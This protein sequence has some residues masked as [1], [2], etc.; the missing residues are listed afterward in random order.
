MR[1]YHIFT[2]RGLG[3]CTRQTGELSSRNTTSKVTGPCDH[4][5]TWSHVTNKKWY[6]STSPKAMTVKLGK[7][8]IYNKGPPFIKFFDALT[9]WW[10]DHVTDKN[11]IFLLPWELWLRNSTEWWVLIQTYYPQSHT[12]C[13]SHGLINSYKKWKML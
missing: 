2:S 11:V 5:A 8:E 9:T 12:T 7:V 13:W 6:I 1:K 4:V 10:R 3:H